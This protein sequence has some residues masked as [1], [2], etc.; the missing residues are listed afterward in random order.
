[1]VLKGHPGDLVWGV[2]K[3]L[4]ERAVLLLCKNGCDVINAVYTA[5]GGVS[6]M[7]RAPITAD[8]SFSGQLAAQLCAELGFLLRETQGGTKWFLPML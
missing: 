4:P 8:L 7:T 5:M 3:S 2:C 1:M 6:E